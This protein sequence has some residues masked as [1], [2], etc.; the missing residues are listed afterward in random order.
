MKWLKKFRNKN[1][2]LKVTWYLFLLI[3]IFMIIIKKFELQLAK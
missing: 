2:E 3:N 1:R